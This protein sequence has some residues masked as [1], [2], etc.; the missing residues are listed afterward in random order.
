MLMNDLTK[1]GELIPLADDR[2]RLEVLIDRESDTE[3]GVS[4]T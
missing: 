4:F 1:P 3:N 2:F